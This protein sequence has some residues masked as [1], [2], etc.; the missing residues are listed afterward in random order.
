M[1]IQY[2]TLNDYQ[3][4]LALSINKFKKL[5]ELEKILHQYNQK[6][7]NLQSVNTPNDCEPD[8]INSVNNCLQYL[9]TLEACIIDHF[10]CKY[11]GYLQNKYVNNDDITDLNNIFISEYDKK[12]L[13]A[14]QC[15]DRKLDQISKTIQQQSDLINVLLQSQMFVSE[16]DNEILALKNIIEQKD[17]QISSLS[18]KV[19]EKEEIIDSLEA[20]LY[21]ALFKI[22]ETNTLA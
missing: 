16:K 5:P 22:C 20:N 13:E 14:Q 19:K 8:T 9:C 17:L 10:L 4:L 11:E 2:F 1:N 15:C 6:L 7:Q 21:T 12:F 18:K 3:E